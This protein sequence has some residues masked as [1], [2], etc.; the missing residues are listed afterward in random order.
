M[1][2]P[3]EGDMTLLLLIKLLERNT[4]LPF[5]RGFPHDVNEKRLSFVGDMSNLIYPHSKN[6][7]LPTGEGVDGAVLGCRPQRAAVV[8]FPH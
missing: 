7:F 8:Q 1:V 3:A 2:E 4:R 6:L 5:P